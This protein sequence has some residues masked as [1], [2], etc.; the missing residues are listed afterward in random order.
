MNF[1]GGT[2]NPVE[3]E[4]PTFRR[5]SVAIYG[6][7]PISGTSTGTALV[8]NPAVGYYQYDLSITDR[9]G[10][11]GMLRQRS[12]IDTDSPVITGVTIPPVL[13]ATGTAA[14]VVQTFNPTGS[15]DLEA[16]DTDLFLRY[17]ALGM[18]GDSTINS[19][20]AAGAARLRF[21]RDKVADWHTPWQVFSDT[22][23][24]T[25]FG[26]GAFLSNA[27]VPMPIPT[28]RGMEATDTTDSPVDWSD[29]NATRNFVGFKPNFLGIYAFDVRAS[30]VGSW[31]VPYN[32]D[33]SYS[34]HG[35]T[36]IVPSTVNRPG[37]G[38]GEASYTEPIFANIV[39]NG[40]RWA[41]KDFG[42]PATGF[43]GLVTWAGFGAVGTT[44]TFRANTNSVS[45]QPIFPTVYLVKWEADAQVTGSAYAASDLAL[46]DSTPGQWVYLAAL[47]SNAPSNPVLF[48]QG[49]TRTWQY[50]FTVGS[51]TNGRIVQP[52]TAV[53]GCYRAI[54]VDASGDGIATQPFGTGCPTF[55]AVAGTSNA[56]V[57]L[58]AYGPGG[59]T[60]V[61]GVAPAFSL[62]KTA[63]GNG[64]VRTSQNRADGVETYVITPAV[65]STLQ[66]A[67][68][69]CTSLTAATY[70][71]T[72]AVTCTV[73]A[74][75]GSRHITAI[76][77]APS[78]P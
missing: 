11:T 75:F 5:D 23:L 54:G 21:R 63:G 14:A 48:D 34:N 15:D 65:G 7:G 51:Q 76:F 9:A 60:M 3:N 30:K 10:N 53:G 78:I 37:V 43:Q 24:A 16:F 32:A 47:Q 66:Q 4:D 2:G 50:S 77:D 61:A 73:N 27:G 28:I 56:S 69:G 62:T 45:S 29:A 26:P 33:P 18:V 55:A 8:D 67:P 22:L 38:D 20:V 44:I 49:S 31:T 25:P 68:A 71:T 1:S 58:R 41:A 13:G 17:P 52:G 59:G 46:N 12:V 42:T 70:P 40:T 39:S 6:F 36:N 57:T 74:G 64:V 72:A 19:Q 35:M